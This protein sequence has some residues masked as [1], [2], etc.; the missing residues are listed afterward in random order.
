MLHIFLLHV[1]MKLTEEARAFKGPHPVLLEVIVKK[2]IQPIDPQLSH[3][4][5]L[6]GDDR[7]MLQKHGNQTVITKKYTPLQFFLNTECL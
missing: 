5:N 2:N 3:S 4:K 6:Q 1:A 7:N